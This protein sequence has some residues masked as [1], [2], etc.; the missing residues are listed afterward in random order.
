TLDSAIEKATGES[1]LNDTTKEEAINWFISSSFDRSEG[2]RAKTVA[3][4][5]SNTLL[6]KANELKPLGFNIV[7]ASEAGEAVVDVLYTDE[8][9]IENN[10]GAK[11]VWSDENDVTVNGDAIIITGKDLVATTKAG[12]N[13]RK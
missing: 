3:V 2:L 8:T 9:T 11:I 1:T 13:I 12:R 4:Q 6:E 7:Q 5:G 10:I